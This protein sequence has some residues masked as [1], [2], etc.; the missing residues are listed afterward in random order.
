ML[1]SRPIHWLGLVSYSVYLVH[2]GLDWVLQHP[3]S[4]LVGAAGLPHAYTLSRLMVIAATILV[5]AATFYGVERPA[6]DWMRRTLS[7]GRARPIA[8][9]P[10]AP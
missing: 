6:R 3:F 5:A 10:S 2:Q 8:A 7:A 4:L 1:S 9:E